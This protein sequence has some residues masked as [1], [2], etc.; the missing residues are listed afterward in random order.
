MP[1]ST[2]D[3]TTLVTGANGFIGR[4]LLS[5]L[6]RGNLEARAAVRS[7]DNFRHDDF[8]KH[9]PVYVVKDIGPATDWTEALDGVKSVVHLAARVHIM[10][11]DA[12]DPLAEFRRVNTMGTIQLALQAAAAGVR[13][14]IYVSTIKVNGE[15]TF[16][17]PFLE[18]DILRP[19]D[20]YAI[21]K[22]EAEQALRRISTETG[23][24]IVIVRPP[25]VYGPGVGGNFLT[26]LKWI[27]RGVPLPLASV[28]NR[29]SL[30][31]LD[32]LVSLLM[33][34]LSQPRA[35]GE[36]FL[37]S[38]GEDLSTPDLLRRTALALGKSSLLFPCPVTLLHMAAR[39][40][41][42]GEACERLCGS[43]ALDTGKAQ[44]LLGWNAVSTVDAELQRTA[45][46][47]Q[48]RRVSAM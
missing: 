41:S 3:K 25:L 19:S 48:R 24:E 7:R 22:W 21:S 1:Y 33:E 38:D 23:M 16:D 43:L 29:R 34:C 44:R 8:I 28:D 2:P 20:P 11:E 40:F 5:G 36:T 27:E 6:V 26:M 31:G 35:A 12:K 32:N 14:L 45:D 18:D 10:R 37:V 42:K 4:A 46:W 9:V 39:L 15:A 47:Y 13:R 17:R 30:V